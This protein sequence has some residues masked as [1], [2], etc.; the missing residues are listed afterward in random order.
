MN[1]TTVSE[2][3]GELYKSVESEHE[4]QMI[5]EINIC[6]VWKGRRLDTYSS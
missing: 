1:T 5:W 3:P 2:V 6:Q 4:D